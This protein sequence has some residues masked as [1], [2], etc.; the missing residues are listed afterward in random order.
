MHGGIQERRAPAVADASTLA[1]AGGRVV[2]ATTAPEAGEEATGA[3]AGRVVMDC[4]RG[5]G[6][7]WF[8]F[9]AHVVPENAE[10]H[11]CCR[12]GMNC[13]YAV[14]THAR[15]SLARM[16]SVRG[17]RR[18]TPHAAQGRSWGAGPA[19]QMVT[20]ERGKGSPMTKW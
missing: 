6:M 10:G 19:D 3:A 4:L 20:Y 5:P 16:G 14:G 13:C 12:G 2:H 8:C 18:A 7:W 9:E 1:E 15:T 11:R 17:T